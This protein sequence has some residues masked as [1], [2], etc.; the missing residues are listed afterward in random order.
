[1][2]TEPSDQV[3]GE[4]INCC[5]WCAPAMVEV[6]AWGLGTCPLCGRENTTIVTYFPHH[7]RSEQL[8]EAG[9]LSTA[10][11]YRSQG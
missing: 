2:T 3:D 8:D 7:L 4:Q 6:R 9:G 1:M 11:E 5:H 10:N